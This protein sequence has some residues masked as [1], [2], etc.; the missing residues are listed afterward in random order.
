MP[1]PDGD[2]TDKAGNKYFGWEED[3]D[4]WMPERSSRIAPYQKHTTDALEHQT[5]A[6]QNANPSAAKTSDEVKGPLVD[7]SMD[8]LVDQVEGQ[9]IF[10][11]QRKQCRSDLLIDFLNVF[12]RLGGFDNLLKRLQDFGEP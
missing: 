8:H 12:G 2:K 5:S 11:V 1:H 7:D 10:A 3:Y 4:E 9:R 6:A